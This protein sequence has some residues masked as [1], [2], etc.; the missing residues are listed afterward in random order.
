MFLTSTFYQEDFPPILK[1]DQST[2]RTKNNLL[3]QKFISTSVSSLK[4]TSLKKYPSSFT[5]FIATSCVTV[6][7]RSL[8]HLHDLRREMICLSLL[9]SS[10]KKN[11]LSAK[12]KSSSSSKRSNSLSNLASWAACETS[13][14]SSN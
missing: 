6:A 8:S 10:S 11:S 3:Y 1:A 9:K 4:S 5:C 14:K 13:R 7:S 12:N 2:Q